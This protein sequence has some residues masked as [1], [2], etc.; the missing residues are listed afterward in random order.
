MLLLASG[1]GTL[2][3]VVAGILWLVALLL[4]LLFFLAGF[5][6]IGGLLLILRLGLF[7]TAVGGDVGLLSLCNELSFGLPLGC[8]LLIRVGVPSR[9]RFNGSGV[10]MMSV[11][12]LCL[13]FVAG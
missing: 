4:L 12:S 5:R 2:L 9:L 8:L 13:V 10:F 3:V 6:L 11:F 7:L 1:S